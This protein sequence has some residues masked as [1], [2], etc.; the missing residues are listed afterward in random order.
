[1]DTVI[2]YRQSDH[3]ERYQFEKVV[4]NTQQWPGGFQ[5]VQFASENELYALAL[6]NS[7]KRTYY[8]KL[9][10]QQNSADCKKGF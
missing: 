5:E 9:D 2:N 6:A 8:C 10:L 1:M 4:E 7:K 3:E